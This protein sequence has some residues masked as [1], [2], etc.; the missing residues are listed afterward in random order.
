MADLQFIS[1]MDNDVLFLFIT[2]ML[3]LLYILYIVITTFGTYLAPNPNRNS[4][5]NINNENN[6]NANESEECPICSSTITDKVELDCKHRFCAK[7]IVDW[8]N[9]NRFKNFTCPVCRATVRLINL[10]DVTRTE[11]NKEFYDQIIRY[12]HKNING[13]NLAY[14]C[15]WDFSYLFQQGILSIFRTTS[16]ILMFV[17]FFIIVVYYFLSPYDII[18]D[19]LGL[20][21]F[22]DDFGLLLGFILWVIEKYYGN[23][24]ERI[25]LE[26]HNIEAQ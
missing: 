23:F 17:V 15:F 20:I 22:L 1:G 26:F 3:I 5:Y 21:G 14:S 2:M 10:L 19:T 18:P 4:A 7:C 8:A 16:N 11:Q 6:A 12:N 9:Y 13:Y 24:R 25:E